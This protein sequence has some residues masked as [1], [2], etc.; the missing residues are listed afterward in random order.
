MKLFPWVSPSSLLA[1]LGHD[2]VKLAHLVPNTV[3]LVLIL[4]MLM[5]QQSTC[6]HAVIA[7]FLPFPL[8]HF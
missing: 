7:Y 1:Q 5:P 4:L 3:D 8:Q 6:R 2:W